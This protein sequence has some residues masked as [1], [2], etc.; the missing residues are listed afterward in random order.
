[1]RPAAFIG[2]LALA[3]ALG[4][5]L[6]AEMV[7]VPGLELETH[8]VDANLAKAI[9]GPLHLRSLEVVLA[10]VIVLAA[11]VPRW[12]ASRLAT[13]AAV[14]SVA[15]AATLRMFLLP[16]AYAAWSRV[17]R[18][19]GR[20]VERILEA[21]RCSELASWAAAALVLVLLAVAWLATTATRRVTADARPSAEPRSD[22]TTEAA[23]TAAAA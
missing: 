21:E 7:V 11:V 13:T 20:P 5:V 18:V 2:T 3:T 17:D 8:L 9:A 14:V 6:L 12:L 10:A 16:A 1:M 22:V 23:P 19:A 15:I 4:G